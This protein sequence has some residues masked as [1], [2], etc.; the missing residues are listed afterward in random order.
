MSRV[1]ADRS[2]PT[3]LRGARALALATLMALAVLLL[4]AAQVGAHT[5]FE[6]STPA[7][8]D[9]VSQ[10]V[11]TVVVTFSGEANPV[12]EQFVALDGDGQL[13][14]PAD[15]DVTD[16]RIFTLRFDPPLSGGD[17]GVRW[18]VQA[19]DSHPIEGAFAFT[20][21]AALPT[22]ATST[23]ATSTTTTSSTAPEANSDAVEDPSPTGAPDD[24]VAV[25]E[26]DDSAAPTSVSQPDDQQVEESAARG[27]TVDG[28][29][30][31]TSSDAATAAP[32][33]E[34][35]P[36]TLDEFLAATDGD[37]PGETTATTGRVIGFLG[38]A[39]GLGAFAFL[40]TA[41]R[42]RPG[43]VRSVMKAVRILGAVIAVGAVVEYIGVTRLADDTLGDSWSTSAGFA[44]VLRFVGGV[45]LVA[46][47]GG[48]M[49]SRRPTGEAPAPHALSAAPLTTDQVP[50]SSPAPS[51]GEVP[52]RWRPDGRSV[53]AL[54]GSA[55][56]VVSFWFDGHTVTEGFR[57][58]HAVVNSVHV[59]A[60]SVWVG[61]VATLAAVAWIRHRSSD[62]MRLVEL[63]LRFSRIATVALAA[64]VIAGGVMA[65]L[66]LDS[67]GELT[68]TTWGQVLLLKTA[69]VGIAATGGAVNHFV[70][71]PALDADPDSPSVLSRL[72]STLTAEAI[73]LTFVVTVTAWL[74]TAAT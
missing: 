53:I 67:F 31:G 36:T 41:L 40:A 51:R 58:L 38:V 43:E 7:E 64:V 46:G 60:G 24:D 71:L 29:P 56:V 23:T 68:S 55:A 49:A 33:D 48:V 9:V 12:G 19:A 57:P 37:R 22:N 6:S 52:V 26:A 61:G 72:R 30:S 69:A 8:G 42:G 1:P 11:D 59:V 18:S 16:G 25:V 14:T 10:P 34:A 15:I 20:V 13:R 21:D 62:P 27:V 74:V 32:G 54:V 70:L 47:L 73:V 4:P 63:V 3:G 44:T 5:D 28:P 2:T 39:F 17:V 50:A 45:A 66:V 35:A 65:V